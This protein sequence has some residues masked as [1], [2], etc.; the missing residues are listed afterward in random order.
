[1]SDMFC[2]V[3]IPTIGRQ[4]LTR[5]VQSVLTQ[6]FPKDHFETIVVNDS[7]ADLV[8][9]EWHRAENVTLLNT[10]RVERSLARNCGAA[11]ARGKYLLFLDDDDWI[12]PGTLNRFREAAGNLTAG[13]YCG[14]Y[15]FVDSNGT[16][17][18]EHIPDEKGNCFIRFMSGE[19]QPL[20]ASLLDAN[21]FHTVGGFLP[22]HDLRGGDEDVDLAR[23][24]SFEHNIV[25]SGRLAAV[26]R[27]DRTES[28]TNYSNL[29]EQ[30]RHSR[31]RILN[32]PGAFMRLYRSAQERSGNQS[33]WQGR[34]IWIYLG[35]IL[36]NVHERRVFTAFSRLMYF[37]T[38][39]ILSFRY[40]MTPL[41]WK[42]AA[43]PHNARG[44]LSTQK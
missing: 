33:Y 18:N 14:G 5:A 40:W 3:I 19:W 15:R 29:Q 34:M 31:D 1:M 4:S 43:R 23:R 21:A 28:T 2:S 20:Q 6:E 39:M 32:L 35:S 17:I 44:W 37:G 12:L 36:W 41:F 26:I 25:G 16:T 22:L 27:I 9:E 8:A 10:N 42:G 13:M 24:I 38:G 30:S 11:V 7:G